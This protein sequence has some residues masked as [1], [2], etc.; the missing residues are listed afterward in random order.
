[1]LGTWQ[2]KRLA[3]KTDILN[4]INEARETDP[5]TRELNLHYL[6]NSALIEKQFIRGHIR[7]QYRH[8]LEIMIGPRTHKGIK[9]YHVITPF[10]LIDGGTILVNRGWVPEEKKDQNERSN[11]LTPGII[12][13][14]G[15]ARLPEKPNMFVPDN[16]PDSGNWYS[17][18]IK[19]IAQH[20]QL[21]D[22]APYIFY[23]EKSG[24]SRRYPIPQD[25][26]WEPPNNHLYYAIFWYSMGLVLFIMYL[27]R[28]YGKKSDE[29][30][31]DK[32]EKA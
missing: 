26:T 12:S 2:V 18:N 6:Q 24:A 16:N 23:A 10:S 13:V 25:S 27:L 20:T 3:W 11:S 32:K 28:F 7:G 17:I 8:S 15:M 21:K 31:K 4:E 19:Q 5:A 30:K 9:G 29:P 22:V 14:Y 1:M